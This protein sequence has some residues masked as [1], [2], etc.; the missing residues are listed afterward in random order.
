MYLFLA[1]YAL[2]VNA[3]PPLPHPSD[4]ASDDGEGLR[5]ILTNGP[6]L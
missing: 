4:S 5:K 6:P 2:P 3:T 1:I